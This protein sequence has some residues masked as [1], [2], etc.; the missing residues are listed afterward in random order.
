MRT[1][2]KPFALTRHSLPFEG[3]T[4]PCL[5]FDINFVTPRPRGRTDFD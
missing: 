3:G 2:T 4:N 5:L 1:D